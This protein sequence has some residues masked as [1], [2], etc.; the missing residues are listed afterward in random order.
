MKTPTLIVRLVG[1][2]LL[3]VSILALWGLSKMGVQ[4]GSYQGQIPMMTQM[5][6][7]LWAQLIAGLIGTLFAGRM[8]LILT[9][10]A[11]VDRDSR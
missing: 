8:A 4:T 9:F 11:P 2:Y 5:R 1:I 7:L 10:D 6:M 3:V